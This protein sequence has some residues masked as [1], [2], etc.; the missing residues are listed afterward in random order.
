MLEPQIT[1]NLLQQVRVSVEFVGHGYSVHLDVVSYCA[2]PAT[3]LQRLRLFRRRQAR[4]NNPAVLR[5][6]I[7]YRRNEREG[8]AG[9]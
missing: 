9:W 8:A 1:A 3:E 6:H 4:L 7:D 2:S 5:R